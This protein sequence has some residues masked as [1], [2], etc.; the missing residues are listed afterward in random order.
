[1]D[2]AAPMGGEV[3]ER[4]RAVIATHR[5]VVAAGHDPG[6]LGQLVGERA[7]TLARADG[8]EVEVVD[9]DGVLRRGRAGLTAGRAALSVPLAHGRRV[10]GALRVYGEVDDH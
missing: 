7:R 8:G 5:D 6:T 2:L 10:F 3:S 1:V 9:D 4:L